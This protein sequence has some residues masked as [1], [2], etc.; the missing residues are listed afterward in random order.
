[1]YQGAVMRNVASTLD[2][3]HVQNVSFTKSAYLPS[4]KPFGKYKLLEKW[5]ETQTRLEKDNEVEG[6]GDIADAYGDHEKVHP[7]R[8]N[9]FEIMNL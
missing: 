4:L 9:Q 3:L 5:G 8:Q 6:K 7:L 1:M 2:H